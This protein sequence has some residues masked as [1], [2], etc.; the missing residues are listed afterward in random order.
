MPTIDDW[1]HFLRPKIWGFG[2]AIFI[3]GIFASGTFSALYVLGGLVAIFLCTASITVN[4]CFDY[5]TDRKSKQLYRFPVASGK[6]PRGFAGFFSAILMLLSIAISYYLGLWAFYLVL[7]ANFT[8]YAYSAPPFRIKEIPYLETF[9]NGMG[10]GW[11]PYYLALL[12]SGQAIS[13]LHHLLGLIPFF[14]SA[15]GHILLQVRDIEDDKRGHVVTTSTTLGLAKMKII[16]QSMILVSGLLI[17]ILALI[18]FLNL[19]A[20]VS[21]IAG[22]FVVFEHKRMKSEV[23]KSYGKLQSIYIIGGLFFILSILRF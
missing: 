13:Y 12:I 7:F 11:I 22:G 10:Y 21:I 9:W 1:G 3:I 14:I 17:I 15:S 23:E 5:K 8:I 20:W 16:S 19:L 6:I 4:H 2:L 18:G